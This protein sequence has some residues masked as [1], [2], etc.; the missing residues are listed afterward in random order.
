LFQRIKNNKVFEGYSTV[1]KEKRKS[2][3]VRCVQALYLDKDDYQIY[4]D[5]DIEERILVSR[6]EVFSLKSC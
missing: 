1:F 5:P 3:G 4:D 2:G 6:E